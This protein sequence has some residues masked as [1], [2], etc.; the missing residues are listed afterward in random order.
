MAMSARG[1]VPAALFPFGVTGGGLPLVTRRATT[2]TSAAALT[3]D[4][5]GPLTAH[6]STDASAEQ[7]PVIVQEL[8][9]AGDAPEQAAVAVLGGDFRITREAQHDVVSHDLVQHELGAVTP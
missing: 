2:I 3:M 7:V 4:V 8:P 9:G 1:R 5:T 6:A